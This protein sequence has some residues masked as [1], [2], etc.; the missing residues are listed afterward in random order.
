M[1]RGL[2]YAS[3]QR[4]QPRVLHEETGGS[5]ARNARTEY[6]FYYIESDHTLC[7]Q[8][9]FI[10]ALAAWYMAVPV[11]DLITTG[12]GA[13][14]W[15]FTRKWAEAYLRELT[16]CSRWCS[17]PDCI[18]ALM[19]LPRATTRVVLT[20][21]SIGSRSGLSKNNKHLPRCHQK[22]VEYGL[23]RFDFFDHVACRHRDVSP[24]PA[25]EWGLLSDH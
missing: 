6:N 19:E 2:G 3:V 24:C 21:H 22:R 25:R 7:V 8:H 16:G 1:A 9:E 15:L 23:N 20:Q 5:C 10:G 17:C 12:I 4:L 18:A 14:G 11:P 13:S